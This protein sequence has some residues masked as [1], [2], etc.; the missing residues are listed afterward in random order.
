MVSRTRVAK[1]LAG[2]RD[3]KP[4]DLN[5]V[6]AAMV[7]LSELVIDIPEIT[8][9]DINPLLADAEGV[10]ALDA[11]VIVA[12]T[13]AKP[14][15]LAIRPYPA[16]LETQHRI[17]DLSLRL[18]PIKPDDAPALAE[19]AE[20]TA[21]EDLRLRF[22]AGVSPSA[23]PA[24]RLSQIDYDREMVF[25]AE[26]GDKSIGGVVRLVFNPEFSSAECAI[27]V[28][29]DMQHQTIGKTLLREALGYAQ[30]RGARKVW[31]DILAGNVR[32]VDLARRLGAAVSA[33]PAGSGLVRAEF[34]LP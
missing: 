11:R 26:L 7:S 14:D 13:T 30:A 8:E 6:T 2:Y 5:A 9:L 28:R 32:I 24:V 3:R 34:G 31:G 21:P 22:H 17:G 4:A 15:R 19:M 20:R 18:R 16:E 23:L 1:L 29:T 12:P 33:G 27:I 25:I 10:I